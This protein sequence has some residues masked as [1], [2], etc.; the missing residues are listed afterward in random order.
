MHLEVSGVGRTPERAFG[1]LAFCFSTK[2]RRYDSVEQSHSWGVVVGHLVKKCSAFEES[3]HVHMIVL[4]DPIHSQMNLIYTT[5][6]CLCNIHNLLNP[7]S[8]VL[9]QKLS[10]SQ[11]VKNSPHFMK[12]EGLQHPATRPYRERDQCSPCPHPISW[13]SILILFYLLPL[14]HPSG[15]FPSGFHT[16]TLYDPLHSPLPIHALLISSWF[17]SSI[18]FGDGYRS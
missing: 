14:D 15:F 9:L 13:K 10:G 4:L 8:R 16:K 2:E 12:S 11:I 18:I 17:C 5:T 7:W 6:F 1:K 3:H